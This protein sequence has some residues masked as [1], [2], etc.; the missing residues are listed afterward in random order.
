MNPVGFQL[1][2]VKGGCEMLK[3]RP[4]RY[5]LDEAMEGFKIFETKEEMFD[6]IVKD[7]PGYL[8]KDDLSI[9]KDYGPDKRIDWKETR[10]ILTRQ[11]GP[12][13]YNE[14]IPIGWCSFE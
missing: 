8:S 13:S 3:Y 11:Y 10:M 1:R 12:K 9:S 14:P 4:H 5:F 6:Y 7:N 2:T